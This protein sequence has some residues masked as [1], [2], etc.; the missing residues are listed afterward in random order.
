[1][2]RATL[3]KPG[4]PCDSVRPDLLAELVV[5]ALRSGIENREQ[6][7]RG[8]KQRDDACRHRGHYSAHQIATHANQLE[9][10][11]NGAGENGVQRRLRMSG[12][13]KQS[14]RDHQQCRGCD[15]R[16]PYAASGAEED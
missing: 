8:E 12:Q 1:M 13:K 11:V 2:V 15:A 10:S 5:A 7:D 4:T 14:Q 3:C 6:V 9:Q 16:L